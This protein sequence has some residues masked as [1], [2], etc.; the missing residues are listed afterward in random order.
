VVFLEKGAE[1]D[2]WALEGWSRQGSRE[3]YIMRSLV[4]CSPQE[5]L[6]T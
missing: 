3:D 6:S 1:G 2:V 4:T 5:L